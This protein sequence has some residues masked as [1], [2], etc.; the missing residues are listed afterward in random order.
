MRPPKAIRTWLQP[1]ELT[2]LLVAAALIDAGGYS[3]TTDRILALRDEGHTAAAIAAA[4]G[5]A[6]P[7]VYYHLGKPP[8][9]GGDAGEARAL[10]TLLGYAGPRIGEALALRNRDVRLHAEPRRLD[11]L[12]SKTPTG[13]REV[14][15]SPELAEL[16][17][18]YRDQRH[19]RGLPAGNDD[20]LWTGDDGRPR[21]YTWAL[22]KV[23]RAARIATEPSAGRRAG[24]RRCPTS[25]P[26]PCATPTSPS[27]CSS[28]TTCPTSWSRW[29][30]TTR[31]RRAAS[32]AT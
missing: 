14:H 30:T 27:C 22:K 1:D 7:T 32:T 21:S 23:K 8:P 10:L 29:A 13:V 25:R 24:C 9:G 2:H 19:R 15:L 5:V 18:L 17:I 4:V 16:P 11:V 28:P 26:T 20:F 12:D 6:P 31:P 3:A